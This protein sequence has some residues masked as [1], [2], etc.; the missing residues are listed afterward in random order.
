LFATPTQSETKREEAFIVK[1]VIR[2]F[3]KPA[4]GRLSPGIQM[5]S[6]ILSALHRYFDD[7]S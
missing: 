6:S 3:E 5:E 7:A 4:T 1:A 2:Y